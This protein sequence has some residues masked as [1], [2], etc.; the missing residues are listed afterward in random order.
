MRAFHE[1]RQYDTDFHFWQSIYYDIVFTAH[2]HREVELLYVIEGEFTISVNNET[3]LSRQG[4]LIICNS[5]DIH[6]C[7]CND[8]EN[9]LDIIVFDV[10]IIN[11]IYNNSRFLL[12]HITKSVLVESGI[13]KIVHSLFTITKNELTNKQP[14]Y[15]TI[16]RGRLLEFWAICLRHFQ[17]APK[18]AKK[19]NRRL[20]MLADLQ[21]LLDYIDSNYALDISLDQAAAKLNFSSWHFSKMFAKLTGM[22]FIRYLST[23][24]VEKAIELIVRSPLSIT[25]IALQCGFNNTR[26]FNRVFKE[27]SGMTPS[28]L[29][30]CDY[31][32]PEKPSST[33]RPYIQTPI[34]SYT[35]AI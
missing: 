13:D 28:Q 11:P 5:G 29:A 17:I 23:I 18:D 19:D 6:Y 1:K 16:I 12:P 22:N 20:A 33:Q 3:F 4:D 32:L 8:S 21:E 2:W 25:E 31:Q 34:V 15:K 10:D 26:T 24:R 27:I 7:N 14:H 30:K 35:K 9:I